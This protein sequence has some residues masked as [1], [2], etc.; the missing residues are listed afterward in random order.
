VSVEAHGGGG[1]AKETIQFAGNDAEI[2]RCFAVMSQLRPA[3]GREEYSGLAR[4]Q[5]A[6][7]M[8]TAYL[9]AG[10]EVVCVANI[11]ISTML[12]T[13]RTIYVEDLVTDAGVRSRGYGQRMLRW[14]MRYGQEQGCRMMSLE[15]GT[16]RREAHA[17]YFRQGMRVTD[18]HFQLAL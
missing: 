2:D 15:S 6:E 14:L 1:P 18:F 5:R 12:A 10:G 8:R 4:M 17:F 11:R 13:G 3:L 7:G 9:E 16:Q